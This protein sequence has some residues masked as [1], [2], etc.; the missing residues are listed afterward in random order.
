MHEFELIQRFFSDGTARREEVVLGI[1][2]DAAL[3][4][5]NPG[6]DIVTAITT[7]RSPMPAQSPE[8]LGRCALALPLRHLK[9]AGAVPAWATLALTLHEI[10]EDWLSRFSHGVKRLARRLHVSLIGGDTTHGPLSITVVAGGVL[11]GQNR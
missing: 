6:Q 11:P 1:G 2:D 9:D 5:V 10:D 8:R 7:L 4:R 3:V